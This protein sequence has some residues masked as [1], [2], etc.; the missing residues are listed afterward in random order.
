MRVRN[1]L[2]P[3]LRCS[4]RLGLL[5]QDRGAVPMVCLGVG[6]RCRALDE[7]SFVLGSLPDKGRRPRWRREWWI[8][9]ALA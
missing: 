6:A 1:A 4:V 7:R 2:V 3:A 8:T 5:S 9:R